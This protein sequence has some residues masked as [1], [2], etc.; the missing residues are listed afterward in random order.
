MFELSKPDVYRAIR[1]II[2]AVIFLA[3]T[4]LVANAYPIS[5]SRDKYTCSG[6]NYTNYTN[7]REET[8]FSKHCIEEYKWQQLRS[9]P[10]AVTELSAHDRVT[11]EGESVDDVAITI[12]TEILKLLGYKIKPLISHSDTN[13]VNLSRFD[14]APVYLSDPEPYAQSLGMWGTNEVNSQFECLYSILDHTR[15]GYSGM[16]IKEFKL[17][18][19]GSL[20][21]VA[22]MTLYGTVKLD[23]TNVNSKVLTFD[24]QTKTYKI[25][26]RVTYKG[27]IEKAFVTFPNEVVKMN[28]LSVLPDY[29]LKK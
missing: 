6:E 2:G 23:G 20:Y 3:S 10:G 1:S 13:G 29:L 22:R 8:S 11:I 16:M 26:H 9:L 7:M 17:G 15:E 21:A 19:N 14:S 4:P 12:D 5:I 27:F 24:L 28:Q 18:S 25:Y